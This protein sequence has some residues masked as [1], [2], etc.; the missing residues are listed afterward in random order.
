MLH[1]GIK[2]Y[3]LEPHRCGEGEEEVKRASQI[4]LGQEREA[5]RDMLWAATQQPFLPIS[6]SIC[7][8][9]LLLHVNTSRVRRVL[10]HNVKTQLCT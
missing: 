10:L 9:L 7:V 2:H 4:S 6:P 3:F 5:A 8:L 1:L